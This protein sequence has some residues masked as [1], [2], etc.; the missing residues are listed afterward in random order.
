[1]EVVEVE[2]SDVLVFL[3]FF[4]QF[5]W[6]DRWCLSSFSYSFSRCELDGIVLW[7]AASSCSVAWSLVA[8]REVEVDRKFNFEAPNLRSD[9]TSVI[10]LH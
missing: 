5:R 10:V 6:S 9:S 8:C 2:M 7:S 4:Q 1:M 3:S